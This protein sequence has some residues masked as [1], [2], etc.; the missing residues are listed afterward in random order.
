MKRD[1]TQVKH[2]KKCSHLKNPTKLSASTTIS[3]LGQKYDH[4][5]T[6]QKYRFL[7]TTL[8]WLKC[9]KC[10]QMQNKQSLCSEFWNEFELKVTNVHFQNTD[11]VPYFPCQ[12]LQRSWTRR[13]IF[14]Y[15]QNEK[16]HCRWSPIQVMGKPWTVPCRFSF[17][18]VEFWALL[19]SFS[20]GLW[21]KCVSFVCAF[22]HRAPFICWR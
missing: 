4:S 9:C 8:D 1:N 22:K 11:L 7:Q 19:W 3:T 16:T 17:I 10:F 15:P 21:K 6:G 14:N 5:H 2:S 13:R 18:K 20:T 12:Q